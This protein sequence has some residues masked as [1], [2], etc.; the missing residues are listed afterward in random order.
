MNVEMTFRD[1][2]ATKF[3]SMIYRLNIEYTLTA[4]TFFFLSV[5]RLVCT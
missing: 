3:I 5:E 1:Y 2:I 4:R